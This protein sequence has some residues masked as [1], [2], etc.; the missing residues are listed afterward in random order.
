MSMSG[1]LTFK[2]TLTVA[3]NGISYLVDSTRGTATAPHAT[4]LGPYRGRFQ[5]GRLEGW[6]KTGDQA[7][8]IAFE[9]YIDGGWATCTSAPNSGSYAIPASTDDYEFRWA[10]PL[11]SE[12]R[13]KLTN[14]AT[15]PSDLDVG[16][17]WNPQ[18]TSGV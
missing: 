3:I 9:I 15:G 8:T 12:F 14:G 16:I 1:P 13:C 6:V 7:V 2:P 5:G 11:G 17:G 10:P 18:R 4:E